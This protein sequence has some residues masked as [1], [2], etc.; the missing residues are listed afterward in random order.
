VRGAMREARG[1]MS[2]NLDVRICRLVSGG[3]QLLSGRFRQ[4]EKA[5]R[6]E[7]TSW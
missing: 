2:N 4:S 1:N 3:A 6:R 7:K 5:G